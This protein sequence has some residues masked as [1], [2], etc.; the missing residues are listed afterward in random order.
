MFRV[1]AMNIRKVRYCPIRKLLEVQFKDEEHIYQYY[2]VSEDVWHD[3][4]N[5]ASM[6]LFFNAKIA[7]CYRVKCINKLKNE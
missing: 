2:D 5:A 3:M 6:D 4:K 1:A 7:T